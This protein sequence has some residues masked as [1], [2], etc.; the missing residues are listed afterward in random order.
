[1]SLTKS[2]GIREGGE[3]MKITITGK[4]KEIAA[5]AGEIQERRDQ[6]EKQMETAQINAQVRLMKALRRAGSGDAPVKAKD[7]DAPASR[8]AYHGGGGGGKG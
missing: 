5:L 3:G 8:S 7:D 4:P 2:W 6:R 1:M